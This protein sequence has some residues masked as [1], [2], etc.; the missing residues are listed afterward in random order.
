MLSMIISGLQFVTSIHFNVFLEPLLEE[1]LDLWDVEIET[2][3]ITAYGG[4]QY[5]NLRAILIWTMH[6]FPAYRI[7]F[8]LVTKGYLGYP[9]CGRGMK[10][11]RSAALA[12]NVWDCMHRRYLNVGH[13]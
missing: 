3:D 13:V 10:S 2:P 9:F 11:Y 4:S 1:L 6:D 7:V 8:G 12:K 5:F